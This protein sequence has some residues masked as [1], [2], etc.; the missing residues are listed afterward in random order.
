MQFDLNS[1]T[2]TYRFTTGIPGDSFAIEV[3]SSLGLEPD[4]IERAKELSGSQNIEFTELLKKMQEEKKALARATY[5]YELKTR[6][7]ESKLKELES[8]EAALNAELKERRKKYLQELQSE[9]IAQ[10]KLYQREQESLK[11]MEREERKSVSERKLQ[12]INNR[13]QDINKEL[14][15]SEI[16]QRQKIRVP[17]EGDRVWLA[18]LETEVTILEI[19]DQQAI[20]DLNGITFKTALENLYEIGKP[21][22]K[23]EMVVI[24][25]SNPPP[26]A[27]FELKLLGLTFEE[28]KPLIDEFLDDAMLA[29]LHTLRIVHGKGTGALRT[30]VRDYLKKKKQVISLE[31]PLPSE[32]GT[33]VTLVKI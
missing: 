2:P 16:E 22:K 31:T 30:K 25:H 3:A 28:A 33:G 10:Q 15:D 4:L 21:A 6:N 32:G 26:K 7:L 18:T 14:S 29:G 23:E 20:V 19:K 13:L 12:D 11:K 1:L 5:E 17:R 8:R 9:L 24:T 27:Q